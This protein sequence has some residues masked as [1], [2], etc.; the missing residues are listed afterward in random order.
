MYATCTPASAN[1]KHPSTSPGVHSLVLRGLVEGLSVYCMPCGG[2]GLGDES[3]L[4]CPASGF[5]D[6][7]SE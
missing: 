4:V 5:D 6:A 2:W 3:E 1:A 7:G